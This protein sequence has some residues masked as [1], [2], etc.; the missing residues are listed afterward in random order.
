MSSA[1]T[2]FHLTYLTPS[3]FPL[4]VDGGAWDLQVPP[5]SLLEPMLPLD[6]AVAC[7]EAARRII[8]NHDKLALFSLRAIGA[9]GSP[10]VSAPLAGEC[11]CPR[12]Q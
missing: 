9:K 1:Y 11:L 3:T 2:N 10:A 7:R 6:A 8:A 12:S 5:A 4:F